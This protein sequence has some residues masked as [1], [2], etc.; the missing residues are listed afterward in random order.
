MRVP[1]NIVL[2]I[3]GKS[4]TGKSAVAPILAERHSLQV[5]LCGDLVRR[6][7]ADLEVDID[8]LT[9][10][11]HQ[12]I[13][14]QTVDWVRNAKAWSLVEGRFLNQVLVPVASAVRLV[15]FEASLQ[16]RAARWQEKTSRSHAVAD[17]ERLDAADDAFRER[18]YKEFGVL[19]PCVTIDTTHS[20]PEE[21]ANC[22][23]LQTGTQEPRH[24]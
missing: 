17:V 4:C 14:L 5:R 7:A 24:G 22:V 18:M 21:C 2:A 10:E 15:H 8:E 9:D 3:Y 1:Q 16:A 13:D 23:M 12:E 6:A 11:R 19:A 20:T